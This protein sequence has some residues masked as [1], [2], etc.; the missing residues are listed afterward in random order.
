MIVDVLLNTGLRAGELCRLQMRDMPHCHGKLVINV[1][2]GKGGIQ[3]SVQISQKL[4]R[5]IERFVRD[6]RRNSKPR[7]PLFINEQGRPLSYES[8]RS[9]IKKIGT[10]VGLW[11]TPHKLR[12][13]YAMEYY[14]RYHD[15]FALQSQLGHKDPK[16]TM[17]YA[18]TTSEQIREQ[19]RKFDL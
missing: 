2:K 16:T 17:I 7:S 14:K 19:V 12:H 9:K 15:I 18:R 3:R 8:L 6:Y 5:R 13:T 4:T 1:R 10:A 11:M